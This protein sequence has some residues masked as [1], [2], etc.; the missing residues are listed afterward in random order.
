MI[1]GLYFSILS[2]V[3]A[4]STLPA[5]DTEQENTI[6]QKTEAYVETYN[7][8]D[9]HALAAFWAEDGEYVNPESGEIIQGRD[10][11]EQAF[12][13]RFKTA[14][15]LQLGLKIHA[16]TFLSADEAIETGIFHVNRS[17]QKPRQ[18]AFKA[19]FKKQNG[20]WLIN[21]I[22]DV[23]IAAAPDQHQHLKELEWLIGE[24]VDQDEDVEI[25]TSYRWDTSK[26]FIFEKFSVTT[27]GDLE[28]EGM[29]VIG[30]DPIRKKIRSWIFDSDGT[31]GE[32]SWTKKGNAWV[33]ETVQT[34]AD[35]SLASSINIYTPINSN[36][37]SWE[38][39]DREVGGQLLPDIGP[40]TITRKKG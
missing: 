29:Q 17:G 19:F 15:D 28:L 2:L 37:Y 4:F 26:N 1:K 33:N 36:S 21:Q 25:H 22:R 14:A 7:K 6:K 23:D 11:I 12:K 20:E 16:I 24:W 39:S 8:H 31:F 32:S 13:S 3:L 35:G 18:S 34:L 10:A 5:Q 27:E 40:I 30:W 9:P 38:S